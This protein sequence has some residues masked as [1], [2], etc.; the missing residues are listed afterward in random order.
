MASPL[1]PTADSPLLDPVSGL[2]ARGNGVRLDGRRPLMLDGSDGAW[3]VTAGEVDVFVV[4][5]DSS[6]GHGRRRHI[7]STVAGDLLVGV[8]NCP[9]ERNPCNGFNPTPTGVIIYEPE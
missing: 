9:Q 3:L 5:L 1:E 6:G 4:P 8:S 2:L 7:G